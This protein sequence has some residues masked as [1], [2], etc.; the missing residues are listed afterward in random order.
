MSHLYPSLY[1]VCCALLLFFIAPLSKSLHS[2]ALWAQEVISF[3]DST[4]FHYPPWEGTLTRFRFADNA[5]RLWDNAPQQRGNQ[6]WITHLYTAQNFMTWEGELSFDFVPTRYNK[7][8]ILLYPY[9]IKKNAQGT[10]S[11]SYVALELGSSSRVQLAQMEVTYETNG[12][13]SLSTPQTLILDKETYRYTEK[14]N[15]ISWVVN[16]DH[17]E[18]WTLSLNTYQPMLEGLRKVGTTPFILNNSSHQVAPHW[19]L[20]VTYTQSN[21]HSIA[22]HKWHYTS[23]TKGTTTPDDEP[24]ADYFS[25]PTYDGTKLSLT[26]ADTPD[27]SQARLSLQPAVTT[28]RPEVVGT[29][30][31]LYPQKPLS[32]GS[33]RLF[34]QG[35]CSQKG[36]QIPDLSFTFSVEK[37]GEVPTPIA[38]LPLRGNPLLSELLCY[39]S[40]GGSEYIEVYNPTPDTID[41]RHF[42]L[43][44]R[45]EGRLGK[46]YPIEGRNPLLPPGEYRAITPW[47]EGLITTFGVAS[48]SLLEVSKFPSLP[49]HKGQIVLLRRADGVSIEEVAYSDESKSSKGSIQGCALE[50]ISFAYPSLNAHNWQW[51]TP[52]TG[53]GT[54]GKRNSNQDNEELLSTAD[55]GAIGSPIQA[56]NYIVQAFSQEG[57]EVS[58]IVVSMSGGRIAYMDKQTTYTLCQSIR[59][60][61]S[62]SSLG[63]TPHGLLL[64]FV[65][66]TQINALPQRLT[67]FIHG[68]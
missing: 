56:A 22:L 18:G 14:K 1:S 31:H 51:A 9:A 32:A 53:Y 3:A 42:A 49:N 34:I 4:D 41:M 21:A 23:S 5:L 17:T 63:Y 10:T 27:L 67:F 35:V 33:Y 11:I 26:C 38:P 24:E 7:W 57:F 20:L 39:P 40:I 58:T 12:K 60:G 68:E 65:I 13:I 16:Y 19:G 48:D 45:T 2:H 54:P 44:V 52:E 29:T 8:A 61:V 55:I 25:P 30:L 47:A 46:V 36:I 6:A 66:R 37:E 50:R 62:L 15:R 64:H 28:L 43:A 59:E